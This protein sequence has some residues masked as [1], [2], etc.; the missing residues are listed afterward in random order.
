MRFRRIGIIGSETGLPTPPF[1]LLVFTVKASLPA[2]PISVRP[3]FAGAVPVA[4]VGVV[5][6]RA[7]DPELA[8]ALPGL[9][10]SH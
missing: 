2:E 3:I 10:K 9:L 1:G 8:T 6:C 5:V 7:I 4:L